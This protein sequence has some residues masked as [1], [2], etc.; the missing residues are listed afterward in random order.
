MREFIGHKI[1]VVAKVIGKISGVM[2]DDTKSLIL[3]RGADGKIT[4][5]VKAHICAF[6]PDDFEPSEYTP[7]LVLFC[8]NKDMPCPG[9]Q[10]IKKGE[11]FSQSDIDLFT[12][13]CPCKCE[14]CRFGS[15]G[16]LRTVS[17]NVLS[18][19]FDGIMFGDYP[20]PKTA[21]RKKDAKHD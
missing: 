14:T 12:A 4:R 16:E 15:R 13:G 19:M 21:R 11:G 9:V 17:G 2:I 20:E 7:F 1:S 18:G 8:E 6:S 10:T 5:V 3:L